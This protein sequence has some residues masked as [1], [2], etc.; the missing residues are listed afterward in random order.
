MQALIQE[1]ADALA[2]LAQSG[3]VRQDGESLLSSIRV[4]VSQLSEQAEKVSQDNQAAQ[5]DPVQD[6]LSRLA[7]KVDLIAEDFQGVSDL[8]SQL[9]S[10]AGD[11][12]A[13]TV[14]GA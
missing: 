1:I 5:P 10:L 8:V 11:L 13:A 2:R 3:N 14:K 12:Q 7:E 9:A 6:Q 4:A